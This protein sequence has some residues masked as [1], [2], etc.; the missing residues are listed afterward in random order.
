ML[1]SLT[2]GTRPFLFP[3][4]TC[5]ALQDCC[6]QPVCP[7]R[8]HPLC[9]WHCFGGHSTVGHGAPK[10][11]GDTE[12]SGPWEGPSCRVSA[13]YVCPLGVYRARRAEGAL[14]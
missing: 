4:A 8:C 3:A 13:S 2:Q 7:A 12:G 5:L 11:R 14:P 10:V 1:R 9:L 6:P